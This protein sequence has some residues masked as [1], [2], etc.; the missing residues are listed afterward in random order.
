MPLFEFCQREVVARRNIGWVKFHGVL[1]VRQARCGFALLK[2]TDAEKIQCERIG[3]HGG[4]R[5]L[6]VGNGLVELVLFV[7]RDPLGEGIFASRFATTAASER[8]KQG[9]TE[10]FSHREV[11]AKRDKQSDASYNRPRISQQK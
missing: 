3:L 2:V 10:N 11:H 8:G 1:Q 9:E 7:I 4:Q 6:K 5:L